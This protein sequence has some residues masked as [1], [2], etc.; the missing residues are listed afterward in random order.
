MSATEL[1][2]QIIQKITTLADQSILEEIYRMVNL[3]SEMDSLYSLTDAERSAV[4]EGMK[5]VTER[6]VYSSEAAEKMIS[7][8]LKSK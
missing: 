3:E 1:K 4:A 7:E 6:H 8:W 2:L 5:D